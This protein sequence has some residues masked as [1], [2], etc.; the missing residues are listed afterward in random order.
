MRRASDCE[1]VAA[2]RLP[3]V[4]GI[5]S[6]RFGKARDAWRWGRH[7]GY[8]RCCIARYCWDTLL[9]RSSALHRA[10]EL[11][12]VDSYGYVRCGIV[13]SR[14]EPTVREALIQV[15]RADWLW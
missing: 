6:H 1:V 9:G 2:L 7:F 13:H 15:L 12:V 5:L 8:P 4:R 3:V 10:C 14:K 11:G